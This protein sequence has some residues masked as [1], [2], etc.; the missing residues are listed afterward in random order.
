M[1]LNFPARPLAA[2]VAILIVSAATVTAQPAADFCGRPIGEPAALE[3]ALAKA[4]GVKK[5]YDGPEY[6]A[7]QDAKSEAMF[8]FTRPAQGPS[9]P[10]AV[11][12][13]P[14][15]DGEHLKLQMEIVCRGTSKGCAA[16]EAEFRKLNAQMEA[17][18][19]SAAGVATGK[20]Q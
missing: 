7:F 10:A 4:D 18:I 16:L 20:P 12:R 2:A 11:C 3:E 5:V 15:K 17:H 8:T 13:K 14:V 19:Q 1:S 6:Y 9:H